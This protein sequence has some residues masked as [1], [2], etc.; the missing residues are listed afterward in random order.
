MANTHSLDLESG[1]SQYAYIADVSQTGLDVTG[2]ISIEGWI[3]LES[4]PSDG[5]TFPIVSKWNG[6]SNLSYLFTYSNDGGVYKLQI[7]WTSG[8]SSANLSNFT[9]TVTLST[10][11]WYHIAVTADVSVPSALF[12]VD[13]TEYASTSVSTGATA[14]YDGVAEFQIGKKQDDT[15]YFDGLI[16][17]V[18]VWSDIRSGAEISANYQKELTGSEANLV[19]YWKLNNNY[20]DETSN[21]NDLTASGSPVFSTD[22]PFTGSVTSVAGGYTY[23]L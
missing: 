2:D 5:S 14:I 18:R 4:L 6:S 23:F 21:N 13:G 12:Y 9:Y 22:V 16:D 3:K 17:E 20:L 11:V 15:V 10:G 19:G 7:F 1:S 8:G